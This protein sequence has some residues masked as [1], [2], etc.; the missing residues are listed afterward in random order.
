ME[1]I[2]THTENISIGGV[3]VILKDKIEMGSLIHIEID[4]LDG[5][6]H[7][8]CQGKVVRC[9]QR[10]ASTHIK[11]SFFD[12]GLEFVGVG[13]GDKSHLQAALGRFKDKEI[14]S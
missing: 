8:K 13:E 14:R 6:A 4:L 2:L 5:G 3:Y 11:S 12:V 7:I 10:P 9:Q 1:G